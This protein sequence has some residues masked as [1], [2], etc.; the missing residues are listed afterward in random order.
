MEDFILT[1][2]K[3]SDLQ[4]RYVPADEDFRRLFE[5]ACSPSRWRAEYVGS[6]V[7]EAGHGNPDLP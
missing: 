6:F 4:G 5:E 3:W 2:W 7:V 1:S